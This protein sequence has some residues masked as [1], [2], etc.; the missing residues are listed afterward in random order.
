[1]STKV[2]DVAEIDDGERIIVEIQGKE[3]AIFNLDGE[4]FAILNHCI[5]QGGPLSEGEMVGKISLKKNDW[6]LAYGDEINIECPWHSWQ[7]NIKNGN[8]LSDN[9]YS[10]PTYETMVKN[11]EIYLEIEE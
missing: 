2:A 10:V 8:S 3:I 6:D 11:G 4:F 7:F 1:M 5:H 9:R